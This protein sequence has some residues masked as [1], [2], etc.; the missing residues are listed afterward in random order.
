MMNCTRKFEGKHLLV[1]GSSAGAED[2]V[3]YAK[4]HGAH[5]TVADYLP[6]ESSS[7]KRL[8]NDHILI[9]TG[10]VNSLEKFI[11]E[12]NVDG[13]ISGISEFNLL[14]AME[15]CERC[16]L[17]FY[18]T[19]EQWDEVALKHRFRKLCQ[20]A[21]VPC[22]RTYYTGSDLS[23]IHW[24]QIKYPSVVKPVDASSSEGVF[25][26]QDEDTLRENLTVSLS[27]SLSGEV[28]I[29]QCVRGS[30]FTAHYTI[31]N[32]QPRLACIDNRYPV[33]VHQGPV[34]TIPVARL[35]PCLFLEQYLDQV[36]ESMVRLCENL[37]LNNAV[38]FIQGLYDEENDSFAIFEAGLRSAAECPCRFMEE[39][40]GLN[41]MHLLVDNALLG[42]SDYPQELENP[43]LHGKCCGIVSFVAKG[44]I[45]GSIQG[46]EEAVN[47]TPSVLA[48]ES[49]YPVGSLT[50]NGN[51]LHQ[52]MIRF[53]MACE[54]REE[55]ARDIERLNSLISVRD[56]DGEDMVIKMEPKR[57][58]GVM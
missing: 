45:V 23:E 46:L 27:K 43:G 6:L 57:V 9:S 37:N 34:T 31:L 35:F 24:K 3:K 16:N 51:T 17:P 38:L 20:D 50:P 48:Y 11:R 5:V 36:N 29:E 41:Y 56:I 55:M 58:F 7:A 28:I 10:D 18:C 53:V 47:S 1:L 39:I 13:V 4:S 26:C 32:G 49:R 25:I 42:F 30:E 19:K 22:P 8:A 15:L 12:H 52:L 54:N 40:N 2:I 44:G 21:K 14:K 33:A